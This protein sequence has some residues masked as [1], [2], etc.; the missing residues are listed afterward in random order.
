MRPSW[1]RMATRRTELRNLRLVA[2]RQQPGTFRDGGIQMN[3]FSYLDRYSVLQS[4]D[5]DFARDRLFCLYGADQFDTPD[6]AFGVRANFAPLSSIGL[7]FCAYSGG[8][9]LSFPESGIIRQFFSI[10]GAAEYTTRGIRRAIKTSS[11]VISGDSRLDLDFAPDYRQLVLRIDVQALLR[12]LNG[13]LEPDGDMRLTFCEDEPDPVAGALV[14]RDV[15]Q[16]AEELERFGSNYSPL[17]L[18]ELERA[19]MFRFLLAH[20]HNYSD[21]LQRSP[22]RTN[23]SVIDIVESYIEEHWEEPIDFDQLVTITGVSMRTIYR[24]FSESGRGSP[25]QFAKRV[26]LRRAAEL[27]READQHTSVVSVAFKCGFQ[28]LGRFASEYRETTGELPSET[29]KSA[30]QRR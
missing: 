11:A 8:A 16:L 13:I 30:R 19:L 26:R 22:P 12:L 5:V 23:R 10:Q 7:A 18:A 27:L 28:N 29:L 3:G 15:F 1:Q 6:R 17:A 4:R 14:R 2:S 25:G 9:S 21:R 24:E 20:R